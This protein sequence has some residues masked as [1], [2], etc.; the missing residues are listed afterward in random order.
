M[1]GLGAYCWDG[2]SIRV[3]NLFLRL[4]DTAS[5]T[6]RVVMAFLNN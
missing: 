4:L 2:A 1:R 6:E 5:G 3:L